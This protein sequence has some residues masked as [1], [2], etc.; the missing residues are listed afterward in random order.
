MVYTMFAFSKIVNLFLTS[1]VQKW[2]MKEIENI[3]K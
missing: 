2:I 3:Q 1:A